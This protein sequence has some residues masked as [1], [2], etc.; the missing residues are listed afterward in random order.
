M[1]ES[2][3]QQLGPMTKVSPQSHRRSSWSECQ[4]ARNQVIKEAAGADAEG[5]RRKG[6]VKSE[7]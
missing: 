3:A 4:K 2:S 1:T 7:S 6:F 5:G